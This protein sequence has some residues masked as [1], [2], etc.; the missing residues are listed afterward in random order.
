MNTDSGVYGVNYLKRAA[1]A[2][3]EIGMNRPEDSIYPDTA[4][5]PLDGHNSYVMHYTESQQFR[6]VYGLF[7]TY[8]AMQRPLL[9][10]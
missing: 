2:M 4:A 7:Q 3:F 6:F 1:V 9:P 10:R 8:F 5:T